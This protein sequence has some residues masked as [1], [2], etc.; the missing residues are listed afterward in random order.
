MTAV[1]S[2][3]HPD[4]R[5]PDEQ[6]VS[7]IISNS[8]EG[9]DSF[10]FE[11]RPSVGKVE[12]NSTE[13]GLWNSSESEGATMASYITDEEA[14]KQA[15]AILAEAQGGSIDTSDAE[16]EKVVTNPVANT[17]E[18]GDSIYTS[19][20]GVPPV[21]E[22]KSLDP[23]TKAALE[24]QKVEA[25]PTISE[26][27]EPIIKDTP[28]E[29]EPEV[30]SEA[31]APETTTEK[32]DD[33]IAHLDKSFDESQ[34]RTES[35]SRELEEAEK[36]KKA[37]DA[38]CD[39]AIAE[40]QKQKERNAMDLQEVANR[41]TPALEREDEFRKKTTAHKS[42]LVEMRQQIVSEETLDQAA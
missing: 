7:D 36:T 14:E 24:S 22:T 5:L 37:K 38:E 1:D 34:S 13:N 2:I 20:K 29:V 8:N 39:K 31:P 21:L 26:A 30:V 32:I 27:P 10:A 19:E 42:G 12:K 35:Y 18:M 11:E 16:I 6:K 17:V 25:A 28:V 3:E 4:G 33:V 9:S 41:V 15:A 40:A 23:E